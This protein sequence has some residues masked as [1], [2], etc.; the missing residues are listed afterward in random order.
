[1]RLT[2][3]GKLLSS[4]NKSDTPYHAPTSQNLSQLQREKELNPQHIDSLWT[5]RMK[6][7]FYQVKYSLVGFRSISQPLIPLPERAALDCSF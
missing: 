6:F 4:K 5:R 1:M 7:S 2:A 3:A